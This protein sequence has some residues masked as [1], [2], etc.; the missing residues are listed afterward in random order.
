MSYFRKSKLGKKLKYYLLETDIFANPEG[1]QTKIL[2]VQRSLKDPLIGDVLSKAREREA[3]KIIEQNEKD[4]PQ[5]W[6][7]KFFNSKWS[8]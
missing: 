5:D 4:Q 7:S 8:M 3:Q 1:L 2:H 6:I